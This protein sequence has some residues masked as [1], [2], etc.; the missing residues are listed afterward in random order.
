[1]AQTTED[2]VYK[3]MRGCKNEQ[4]EGI[5]IHI[6]AQ[7]LAKQVHI[8]GNQDYLLDIARKIAEEADKYAQE[9]AHELALTKVLL[10]KK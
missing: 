2:R 7:L 1:M 10:N 4:A 5:A 8:E 6:L 3:A 9:H